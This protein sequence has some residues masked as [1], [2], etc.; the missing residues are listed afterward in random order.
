MN[1][2]RLRFSLRALMAVFTVLSVAIAFIVN[3][4]E[5]AV[6]IVWA[7]IWLVDA[8]IWSGLVDAWPELTERDP[9]KQRTK[10]R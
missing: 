9:N 4:L 2:N 3:H 7:V 1:K 8:A 6:A 10:E 5:F